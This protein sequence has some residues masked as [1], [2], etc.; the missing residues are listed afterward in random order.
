MGKEPAWLPASRCLERSLGGGGAPAGACEKGEMV[1]ETGK[2]RGGRGTKSVWVKG[3]V[4]GRS[5][6]VSL[7]RAWDKAP[8]Q[9]AAPGSLITSRF[10]DLTSLSASFCFPVASQVLTQLPGEHHD[11]REGDALADRGVKPPPPPPPLPPLP[12]SDY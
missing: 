12:P 1:M 4:G 10:S 9:G 3:S 2:W 6:H 11:C 8:A 5:G 7:Y